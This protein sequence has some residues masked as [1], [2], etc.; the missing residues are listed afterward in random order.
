M[1]RQDNVHQPSIRVE[2]TAFLGADSSLF[3]SGTASHGPL[4]DVHPRNP[5]RLAGR[6]VAGVAGVGSSFDSRNA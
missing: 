6:S 2:V 3:S 5:S 4:V 1:A